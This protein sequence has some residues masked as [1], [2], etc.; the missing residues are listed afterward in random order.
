MDKKIYIILSNTPTLISRIIRFYTRCPYNHVSI[1]LDRSIQEM[2]SFGRKIM[3]FP[4]VGGFVKED[5]GSGFYQF[6]PGTYSIVYEIAVSEES[7]QFLKRY[8]NSFTA[9]PNHYKYNFAG[10]IAASL[11]IPIK[12]ENRYFCTQFVSM[13]LTKSNIYDFKKDSC[14]VR[15]ED[16]FLMPHVTVYEGILSE[17]PYRNMK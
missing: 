17:Y 11:N 2:Y 4:L 16:F 14:L 15:P 3:R 6:F 5:I 7:F 13:L 8:I 10:I 12:P 1:S 9:D